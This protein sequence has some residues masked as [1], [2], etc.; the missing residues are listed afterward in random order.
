MGRLEATRRFNAFAELPGTHMLWRVSPGREL[1]DYGLLQLVT[2]NETVL[3]ASV[4]GD[5][6]TGGLHIV[7]GGITVRGGVYGLRPAN[8]DRLP[9]RKGGPVQDFTDLKTGESLFRVSGE[10]FDK[11]ATTV[12]D[13]PNSR[14]LRLPVQ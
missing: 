4:P 2:E 9:Y 12:I 5:C 10:H 14:R 11:R 6:S 7:G 1:E 3:A 8:G 13:L